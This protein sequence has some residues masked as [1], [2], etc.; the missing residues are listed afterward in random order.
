[1]ESAAFVATCFKFGDEVVVSA[2]GAKEGSGACPL[3]API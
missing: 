1:M 2:I 3:V